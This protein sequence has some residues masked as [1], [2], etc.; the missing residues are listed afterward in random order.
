MHHFLA[1]GADDYTV[2]DD[3]QLYN[4]NFKLYPLKA[5]FRYQCSAC[6]Q[7]ILL[8][9]TLPRLNHEWIRI[10]SDEDRIIDRLRAAKESD[11]QRYRDLPASQ[12][13]RW[14]KTSLATMNQYL[15]G[16]LEAEGQPSRRISTRNK[17][18]Q[19]QFGDFGE[20]VFKYIGFTTEDNEQSEKCLVPPALEPPTGG[21]SLGSLRALFEDAR[22]E[23]QSCLELQAT[24]KDSFPPLVVPISAREWLET[25]LG[26]GQAN[27]YLTSMVLENQEAA[28]LHILGATAD[29]DDGLLKYAYNRQVATNP[30]QKDA[31][32]EALGRLALHREMNLQ[33]FVFEQQESQRKSAPTGD[34][35]TKP[36]D[37]FNIDAN[38][39]VPD[40]TIIEIYRARKKGAPAHNSDH[41]IALL[42]IAKDR[43][44]P[45]I[46]NEVFG[47]KMEL[48]EACKLLSVE[49]EWPL[50]SIA[51]MAET[52]KD[53]DPGLVLMALDT[54]S[55][56]RPDDDPNR[57]SFEH[58]YE[59]LRA[60]A[61]V[62]SRSDSITADNSDL[63]VNDASMA[64]PAGL[65]NLRNTC[66]LN[67]ILQ[68]FYSV[69]AVRNLALGLDQPE[70]VPSGEVVRSR[71]GNI[72]E[73]ELSLA[74]AY[75][76]HEFSRELST[77]FR[78]LDES[79]ESVV[80]PRQ[81]LANAALL[82]PD[83]ERR[84]DPP[85]AAMGPSNND[86]PPLPPR[87]GESTEPKVTVDQVLEQSDTASNV[88]SQTLVNQPEEDTTYVV[89]SKDADKLDSAAMDVEM[90]E[91][92]AADPNAAATN[93]NDTKASP[94]RRT[95]EDLAEELSKPNVGTEQM[96]VE[97]VLGNAME[98]LQAAIK[99]SQSG[100]TEGA[101][102]PIEDAFY[103]TFVD[104]R[105]TINSNWELTEKMERW[106]AA[107]PAKSGTRDIYEAFTN[108]F[109]LELINDDRV[110]FT[111]IKRAAPN[112]HICIQ[113]AN[114]NGRKNDNP[115]AIPET[116]YLDRYMHTDDIDSPLFK[117]KK[118]SWDIKA[119]LKDIDEATTIQ[120]LN[121][122][123]SKDEPI[124]MDDV[125]AFIMVERPE[126]SEGSWSIVTDQ[127]T[128][129]VLARYASAD[130]D[131][132]PPDSEPQPPC[133]A[134][135]SMGTPEDPDSFCK[136][137]SFEQAAQREQLVAEHEELF[138]GMKEVA[139][140][141]HA[142]ICH[143]GSGASSGHYWVYIH[144]FDQN[145][146]RRYNDQVV[147]VYPTDAVF[148]ELTTKG[149]PYFL[150]YVRA[151]D[152]ADHVS[153]PPR[154]R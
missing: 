117:A 113:R 114:N 42:N 55:C 134:G 10:I 44:S 96:D 124:T 41:R 72:S 116:L 54:I 106:V 82:K 93:A 94:S 6:P 81:R 83:Q 147:A 3:D 128:E 35:R 88:S 28:D 40:S 73:S 145:V 67:S 148:R 97:E 136:E 78:M 20:N 129:D 118:R 102:D 47:T 48:A 62:Q 64:E 92:P 107:Y 135:G 69:K 63:A 5:A 74:K 85:S 86:A 49:P 14:R 60:Q 110:S 46:S 51:M 87:V 131:M 8:E 66:Y 99:L 109:D 34:L 84:P 12:E 153:I 65:K 16:V 1:A 52:I 32:I 98:L 95:L 111:T 76:G 89:V 137:F 61:H 105:K 26:L 29:S 139:Y 57:A 115:I 126:M 18:F 119:R 13:E 75:V 53:V 127:A 56:S 123:G 90:T 150:S 68:Y 112:F 80:Q 140:R 79:R 103:S 11:P 77:L 2:S 36:Y 141:L 142:V 30:G 22:S 50:E 132:P 104:N 45:E 138:S 38:A 33:L 152:V 9:I 146:W 4:Q 122:S 91:A 24:L 108:S 31:Y 7:N 125:D 59:A 19:V 154:S 120:E 71:L 70:L 151:K 39:N 144:D 149:E 130:M 43:R 37:Y 133:E 100:T 121:S 25:A 58:I 17:T 15:K 23:I 101:S 143:A 21:T 27:N